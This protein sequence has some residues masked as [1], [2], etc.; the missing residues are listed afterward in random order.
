MTKNKWL[1]LIDMVEVKFEIN[2]NYKKPMGDESPGEKHIVVF[3]GPMGKIKLEFTEKARLKDVKTIYS[4]RVGS[5]VTINKIYDE[6]D[7][8]SHMNAY[9]WDE[10]REEWQPIQG[11]L[12]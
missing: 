1:D 7:I 2:E 12:F 6:E 9:K 8:V 10:I 3:T 4:G 5:E 11:E